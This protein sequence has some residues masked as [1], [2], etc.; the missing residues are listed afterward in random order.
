[1]CQTEHRQSTSSLTLSTLVPL[2]LENWV[3]EH[4]PLERE[5]SFL[6][7]C[8]MR[9]LVLLECMS[10]LVEKAICRN[11]TF[12]SQIIAAETSYIRNHIVMH[13][14]PAQTSDMMSPTVGDTYAGLPPVGL[15]KFATMLTIG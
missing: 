9:H 2:N 8:L 5:F 15:A 12:V 7:V 13:H 3:L 4:N 11:M 6:L 10:H 1:M 14:G